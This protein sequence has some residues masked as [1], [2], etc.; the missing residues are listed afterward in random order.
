LAA[1]F[2]L[3]RP[4]SS[5]FDKWLDT[6][7]GREITRAMVDEG[8]ELLSAAERDRIAHEWARDFPDVWR[9]LVD[10]VGDEAEAEQIVLIG[11][12]V[13]ALKEPRTIDPE[14]LE[15]IAEQGDELEADPAETLALVLDPIDL[16]SI[17]EAA[18]ADDVLVQIPDFLDDDAYA[19]LWDATVERRVKRS[20]SPRH[21]GRLRRLVRRLQARAEALDN[22]RAAE[23]L[24]GACA[25]FDSDLTVRRRLAVLLL[26]DAVDLLPPAEEL[27]ALAA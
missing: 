27:A 24:R 21:E 4:N 2:P 5:K 23:L 20:W 18:G 12:I 8:K 9:S 16:W 11:A 25:A 19:V 1:G 10:D 6:Q 15:L 14:V 3:L 22:A 17:V 7:D 26:A 13:A